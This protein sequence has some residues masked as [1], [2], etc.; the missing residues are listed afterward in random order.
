[1]VFKLIENKPKY[2]HTISDEETTFI[3]HVDGNDFYYRHNGI[4]GNVDVRSSSEPSD[5]TTWSLTTISYLHALGE[6]YYDKMFPVFVYKRALEIAELEGV[7]R[8]V[9]D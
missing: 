7:E 9:W 3:S 8:Y 4:D 6:E 2:I 1:M 5:Y